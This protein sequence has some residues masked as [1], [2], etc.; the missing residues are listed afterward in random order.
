MDI[1]SKKGELAIESKKGEEHNDKWIRDILKRR[2]SKE[3]MGSVSRHTPRKSS[4]KENISKSPRSSLRRDSETVKLDAK[5]RLYEFGIS[6]DMED[7]EELKGGD[8][9]GNEDEEDGDD[10][11][12][13]FLKPMKKSE[14]KDVPNLKIRQSPD[15]GAGVTTSTVRQRA[16]SKSPVFIDELN[17]ELQK[18]K[19]LE[20]PKANEEKNK[21]RENTEDGDLISFFKDMFNK[22]DGDGDESSRSN[23][24]ETGKDGKEENRKLS[25]KTKSRRSKDIVTDNIENERQKRTEKNSKSLP[26]ADENECVPSMCTVTIRDTS[27]SFTK[28]I[29]AKSNSNPENDSKVERQIDD[30][31]EHNSSSRKCLQKQS[32]ISENMESEEVR[33]CLKEEETDG[34]KRGKIVQEQKKKNQSVRSKDENENF[35][36]DDFFRNKKKEKSN[37][38]ADSDTAR[39]KSK[40]NVSFDE[41]TFQSYSTSERPQSANETGNRTS[42]PRKPKSH[43]KSLPLVRA[44]MTSLNATFSSPSNSSDLKEIIY[45]QWLE[46]KNV[47]TKDEI[48]AKMLEQKKAAKEAEVEKNERK[49]VAKKTFDAWNECKIE[50]ISKEKK[51]E[52]EVKKTEKEKLEETMQRK[53]DAEKFFEK[54]KDTKDVKLKKTFH[55]KKKEEKMKEKETSRSKMQKSEDS[56]KAFESWKA[57]KDKVIT[58]NKK[59]KEEEK[60]KI[61]EEKLLAFEKKQEAIRAY[62]SW[63]NKKTTKSPLSPKLTQRAWSPASSNISNAIPEKVQPVSF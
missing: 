14:G 51:K 2:E 63:K 27:P 3:E 6:V 21:A 17:E 57:E 35:A 59:K 58:E 20:L 7:E 54:W 40:L 39:S 53:R 32:N 28:N 46:K 50:V 5:K 49:L 13:H 36:I 37:L 25:S 55:Q 38:L 19:R 31:F 41:S 9:D 56:L 18:R 61:G 45:N 34:G 4:G 11:K 60:S 47:Q 30:L 1:L 24:K 44:P 8:D 42:T 22:E 48:K 23:P 33:D 62:D 12:L 29:N 10:I 16:R 26:K 43:N 15:V 52:K